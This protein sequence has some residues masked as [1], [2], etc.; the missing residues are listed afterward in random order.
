MIQLQA[1]FSPLFLSLLFAGDASSSSEGEAENPLPRGERLLGELSCTACHQADPAIEERLARPAAPDLTGAAERLTPSYVRRYLADPFGVKPGNRMPH[2]LAAIE[3]DGEAEAKIE[4]L[5]HYVMSL[6]GD[7]AGTPSGVSL[8]S[9]ER[10]RRIFHERGCVACHLPQER[11]WELEYGYVE[12]LDERAAAEAAGESWYE[13]SDDDE[14]A[15]IPPGTLAHPRLDLDSG[16]LAGKARLEGLAGFLQ[17][18]VSIRKSGRMPALLE[19][20]REARDVATY[21]LRERLDLEASEPAPGLAYE[22]F[23]ENVSNRGLDWSGLVATETGAVDGF[24]ISIRKRGDGFAFRFTGFVDIPEEG[25]WTFYTTSDDGSHLWIN[26]KH[27]VDNGGT[28]APQERSGKIDLGAGRHSIVV[29]MFEGGGGEKLEV[30]WEGPGHSKG[31]I[32][33]ER[34]SHLAPALSSIDEGFVLDEAMVQRGKELFGELNCASCHAVDG[35][36]AAAAGPFATPLAEL[37]PAAGCLADGGGNGHYPFAG[38]GSIFAEGDLAAVRSTL[39]SAASLAEPLDPTTRVAHQMDRMR[40]YSCHGRDGL[41]GVHPDV[42]PYFVANEEAE[43]GDEGRFPPRLTRVG[44]KLRPGALERALVHGEGARPYLAARMPRYGANN[45][46]GL[47]AALPE[48][49]PAPPEPELGRDPELIRYGH[50][51]VGTDGLGCIQCHT[52]GGR[53]SLGVQAV[54]LTTMTERIQ[55]GWYEQLMMDP[56]SLEMNTRMPVFWTEGRSP[57]DILDGDPQA[58][59]R[60]VWAFLQQ[61]GAMAL[62]KGLVGR[63]T[64]YELIPGDEPVICGVFMRDVSPRTLVVGNPELVHYAFDMEDP[65]LARVWRGRFFNSRGTWEGRAGQ[66]E[67]PASSDVLVTPGGPTFA[68]LADPSA[69]WPEDQSS[70]WLGRGFDDERRPVLRYGVAGVEVE[71]TPRPALGGGVAALGREFVVHSKTPVNDLWMRVHRSESGGDVW[72]A[73]TLD[74][75]GW[76]RYALSDGD[77]ALRVDG[78]GTPVNVV[79]DGVDILVPVRFVPAPG[80]GYGARFSVEVTW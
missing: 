19:N 44:A 9:L 28:H 60:A 22:Y 79:G 33:A 80:G 21:L 69:T 53:K 63:D 3:G 15:Y 64:A 48:A 75:D 78:A 10:G 68:R 26:G 54:D 42:R 61:G 57:S 24:D 29:T 8:A 41:G 27:V 1:I 46:A 71:E 18:P 55:Y 32:P 13:E 39:Q 36:S 45:V 20:P 38:E 6:G 70:T 16:W 5:V 59:I 65:R 74:D 66:L 2:V 76:W 23:E 7:P 67:V 58:Q 51:L 50:A 62:P 14:E 25:T 73:P 11:D 52:F 40:C 35:A 4:A 17:D 12:L 43:L 49:D 72:S 30:A 47:I 56:A 77:F 31:A 34:L 37:D